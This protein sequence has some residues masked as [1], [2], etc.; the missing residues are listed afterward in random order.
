M[1]KYSSLWSSVRAA[2]LMSPRATKLLASP[3]V[4]KAAFNQ[5][6][7]HPERIPTDDAAATVRALAAAPWF[8]ETVPAICSLPGFTG[9]ERIEVPVTIAWGDHDR[10]LLPRQAKR[11]A[12]E[13]PRAR[14]VTLYGC[15]HVPMY[16]DPDRVA[17]VLLEG[18]GRN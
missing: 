15:G 13:I 10:L 2:R 8:D 3:T 16:D 5:M 9:G 14:M 7:V 18:S 11:A 12:S 4:R 17:E 1:F 6:V